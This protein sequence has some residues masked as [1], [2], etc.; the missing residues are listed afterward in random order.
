MDGALREA[1]ILESYAK[2]RESNALAALHQSQDAQIQQEM[3]WK[4]LEKTISLIKSLGG[5][6][7]LVRLPDGRFGLAIG[8]ELAA[9]LPFGGGSTSAS[10]NTDL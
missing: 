6:V 1:Q 5:S 3:A 8:G 9:E 2:A 10:S 7:S 4:Q